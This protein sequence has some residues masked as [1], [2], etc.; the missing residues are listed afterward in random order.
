MISKDSK[1]P[2]G[3]LT[4]HIAAAGQLGIAGSQ[5]C[6]QECVLCCAYLQGTGGAGLLCANTLHVSNTAA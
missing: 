5:T 2:R 1:E 4:Q 6:R 3:T